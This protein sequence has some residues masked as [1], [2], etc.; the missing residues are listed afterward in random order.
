MS[1]R[2]Y[3]YYSGCEEQL[4][5]KRSIGRQVHERVVDWADYGS[6]MSQQFYGHDSN[7]RAK[8]QNTLESLLLWV[9][10]EDYLV[11]ILDSNL[12]RTYQFTE[13]LDF[14]NSHYIYNRERAED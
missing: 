3:L 13:V 11:R 4:Q 14:I 12:K 6:Q 5:I 1:A 7:N 8:W 2:I 10:D 9:K